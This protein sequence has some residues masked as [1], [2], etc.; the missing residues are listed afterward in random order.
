M[1]YLRSEYALLLPREA[2]YWANFILSRRTQKAT[3]SSL[4]FKGRINNPWED[5]NTGFL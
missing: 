4:T 2:G 5:R 3:K 1:A